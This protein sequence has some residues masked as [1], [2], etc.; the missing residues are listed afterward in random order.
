[1]FITRMAL[2][3]RTFLRGLGVTVGLPLL[4]AMVPALSALAQSAARPAVR[5]GCYYYPN[6]YITQEWTPAAV[7]AG[8]ELTPILKS[9]APVRDQVLVLSGLA[10]LEAN[11]KGDGSA[12]HPRATAVWLSG[13]H[14]WSSNDGLTGAITL[15]T[16]LDQIAARELGKET[17]LLSLEVALEVPTQVSCDTGD[18][19]YSN[20]ISWRTPTM[21]LPM[22]THPRVVFARLFGD[23]GSAAQRSLQN[24]KTRTI[25]DSVT[26]EVVRLEQRLGASDRSKLGEYLQAV[27]E[28]ERR[29]QRLESRSAEASLEL[30]ER[31]T[32]IPEFWDD[33]AKLMYDLQVLAFQ[34]DVTRVITMLLGREQSP[35]SFP[36]IGVPEQHHSLSHHMDN[37][38]LMGK[39]AKI[40]AHYVAQFGYFLEKLR[41][42]PDG[43]GT[44][45]DHSLLLYG[46][47]LGNS[48]LHEHNNL[49]CLLA[50]AAAG[51]IKGGRHLRYAPNTPQANLFLTILDKLG[52][53]TPEKI[54]DSTGHLSDV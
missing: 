44:L 28:I 53:P 33:R 25:L 39:K 11:S 32:E 14:A 6:G 17:P 21:P 3:R 45:L 47:G 8:F 54:G 50:G 5:L 30:P 23:G 48:N 27:R 18:C 19:F 42:T 22:A 1:M 12:D 35:Q 41:A 26:Q 43:D 24:R 40:D 16:T 52:M 37:A 15:G 36:Q 29:I 4:D 51:T 20:T 13:V 7:G 49:P 31:P 38:G 10:H 34:A 46:G 9:L 2:P